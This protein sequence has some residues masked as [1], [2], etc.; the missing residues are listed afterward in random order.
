M[1]PFLKDRYG[2]PCSI[3]RFGGLIRKHLDKARE[4][5]AA[6]LGAD[7]SEIYFTGCGSESDNMAIKGFCH[8]HPGGQPGHLLR[9]APGSPE[10][11]QVSKGRRGPGY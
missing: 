2:N 7:P 8:A 6:L 1:L 5:V 3:Y 11:L 10:L 4:E 9:R